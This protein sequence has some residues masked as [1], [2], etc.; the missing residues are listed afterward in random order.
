MPG[1]AVLLAAITAAAMLGCRSTLPVRSAAE[2]SAILAVVDSFHAA[3]M[4]EDAARM[5]EVLSADTSFIF[6]G[7]GARDWQAGR[8]A[9]LEKHQRVDW[10]QLDSIVL[11][12]PTDLH[13]QR[14]SDLAVVMYTTTLRYRAGGQPGN[15]ALRFVLTL[16]LEEKRWAVRQG[17]A[18]RLTGSP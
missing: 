18:Q 8:E 13:I 12:T 2:H 15:M 14:G 11:A 1:R 9:F 5:R 7:T 10:A 17:L 3:F 6:F 16:A 4:A